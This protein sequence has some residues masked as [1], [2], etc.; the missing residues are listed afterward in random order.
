MKIAIILSGRIKCYE[1]NLIPILNYLDK[2]HDVSLF[3][4][5]NGE[6]TKYFEEA[7]KNLSKWLKKICYE[8]YE[9][10]DFFK[11]NIHPQTSNQN[12]NGSLKPYN[13][14][15]LFYNDKKAYEMAKDYSKTNNFEYDS[16]CK[17]RADISF[18]NLN[19]LKF[20][21]PKSNTL[22]SVVSHCPI[23]FNGDLDNLQCISDIFAY[24]NKE[25]M[26]EYFKTYDNIIKI[27]NLT[28]GKYRIGTELILTESFFNMIYYTGYEIPNE[29]NYTKILE[30]KIP[31]CKIVYNPTEA[32]YIRNN[33]K[34][35]VCNF[36]CSYN[37]D[38]N[39][40]K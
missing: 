20:E 39:R 10:P 6:K 18:C 32:N 7:E 37:L 31:N 19:E 25:V 4:S 2:Q 9:I 26:E 1:N 22:Y 16:Y 28:N 38:K 33:S 24:G 3:I 29:E 12:I 27:N 36:Y 35:K 40:H 8:V 30:E 23:W 15:S 11:K 34:I 5:I 14:M 13:N 21:Y 17:F